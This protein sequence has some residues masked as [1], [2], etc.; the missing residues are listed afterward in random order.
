M[1]NVA[2]IDVSKAHLDAVLAVGLAR[3]FPNGGSGIGALPEWLESWDAGKGVYEPVDGYELPMAE[4][5]R[6]AGLPAQRVHPN[7]VRAYAQACG[8]PANTGRL[9]AQVPAR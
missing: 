3:R 1:S 4:G 6:Q 5:L 9:D 8:L 7:R 2:G